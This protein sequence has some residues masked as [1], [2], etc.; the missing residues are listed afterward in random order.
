M[1]IRVRQVITCPCPVSHHSPPL[2]G[3]SIVQLGPATGHDP[4]VAHQMRV[5]QSVALPSLEWQSISKRWT[6]ANNLKQRLLKYPQNSSNIF[7][8]FQIHVR[9]CIFMMIH[10]WIFSVLI[11]Y[12]TQSLRFF[13]SS[14][15]HLQRPE[16][17]PGLSGSRMDHASRETDKSDV[18]HGITRN[19]E[20][21]KT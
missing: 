4:H 20:K 13:P 7:N 9:S 6:Q 8:S 14:P 1:N 10:D 21:R 11:R 3:L 5:Q 17:V 15:C 12:P 16:S 19:R 2:E 18:E